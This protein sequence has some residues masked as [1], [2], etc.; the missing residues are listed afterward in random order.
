MKGWQKILSIV[1]EGYGQKRITVQYYNKEIS[2]HY[3]EMLPT[4]LFKSE[5][6][7]WKTAGNRIY[8]YVVYHNS[9]LIW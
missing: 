8:N 7:G 3:T 2:A 9:K 4:D 6:R 5:E 1:L